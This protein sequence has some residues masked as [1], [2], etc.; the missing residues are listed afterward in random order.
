MER[1][2]GY[3]M[4]VKIS[5]ET[6]TIEMEGLSAALNGMPLAMRKSMI[7]D[8][9]REMALHAEITQQTGVAIYFCEPRSPWQCGSHEN[10]NGL[11]S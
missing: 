8:Q 4:L 3:L 7:D 1:T 2:S 5:G 10:I 6:A 9:G 11:I